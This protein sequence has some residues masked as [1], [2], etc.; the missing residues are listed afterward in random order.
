MAMEADA[1]RGFAHL[2][3]SADPTKG[4]EADRRKVATK[5][6][7]PPGCQWQHNARIAPPLRLA[8]LLAVGSSPPGQVAADACRGERWLR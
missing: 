4:T 3:P 6:Q 8:A 2:F 7:T 5:D 1:P